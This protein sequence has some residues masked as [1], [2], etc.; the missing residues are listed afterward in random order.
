LTTAAVLGLAGAPAARAADWWLVA[1]NSSSGC[2]SAS[3][4]DGVSFLDHRGDAAAVHVSRLQTSAVR[5]AAVMTAPGQPYP[6][7]TQ[8][9]QD[10]LSMANHDLANGNA[11]ARELQWFSV[12]PQQSRSITKL[13]AASEKRRPFLRYLIP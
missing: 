2:V 4:T 10:C 6:P 11:A 8:K 3:M 1:L 12:N 9:L 13:Q 5:A 7:F